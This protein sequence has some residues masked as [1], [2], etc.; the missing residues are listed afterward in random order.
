MT[1]ICS[2]AVFAEIYSTVIHRIYALLYSIK[3]ST[4]L[5]KTFYC[6]QGLIYKDDIGE[7]K[8]LSFSQVETLLFGALKEQLHIC[9]KLVI[10]KTVTTISMIIC[11]NLIR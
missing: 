2:N 10:S 6:R 9:T 8:C 7:A 4:K 11:Q 5:L 1:F 3:L